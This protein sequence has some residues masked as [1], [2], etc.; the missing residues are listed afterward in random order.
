[1]WPLRTGAWIA[2]FHEGDRSG[3]GGRKG[4]EK[5]RGHMTSLPQSLQ[6]APRSLHRGIGASRVLPQPLRPQ[7]SGLST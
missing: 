6:R 7:V 5:M 2:P 4:A 1:M 3:C